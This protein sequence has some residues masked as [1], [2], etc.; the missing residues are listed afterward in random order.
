MIPLPWFYLFRNTV[1]TMRS[2]HFLRIAALAVLTSF[3][4][5]LF[6]TVDDVL[7]GG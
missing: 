4:L 5:P 7:I 1:T 3:A 2:L 6:A